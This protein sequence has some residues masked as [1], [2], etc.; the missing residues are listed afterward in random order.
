M[1]LAAVTLVFFF[2]AEDGIRDKLV[3]GVHT[4]ALPIFFDS[5]GA[6]VLDKQPEAAFADQE[7]RREAK[8]ARSVTFVA[9]VRYATAGARSMRNTHPFTMDGRIIDRKSTRLNSS[10]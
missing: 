8:R 1:P 10:H 5:A 9:H 7:F 4:C 3:T 6:P 2:Q